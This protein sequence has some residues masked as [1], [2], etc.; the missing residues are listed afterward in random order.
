MAKPAVFFVSPKGNKVLMTLLK[1]K[2][3][4]KK[5]LTP[6]GKGMLAMYDKPIDF[7]IR[8][9]IDEIITYVNS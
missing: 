1:W 4:M 7:T 9:N 5:E 8:K 6:D 2:I 3:E